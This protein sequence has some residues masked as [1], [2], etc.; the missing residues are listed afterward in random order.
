MQV[1]EER[2]YT[3]RTEAACPAQ[4]E[5]PLPPSPLPA[6]DSGLDLREP[7]SLSMPGRAPSLLHRQESWPKITV[8][9]VHEE[10]GESGFSTRA[11]ILSEP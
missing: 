2:C 5:H 9:G 11:P 6:R 10:P 4:R 1:R 7:G 3:A 8:R